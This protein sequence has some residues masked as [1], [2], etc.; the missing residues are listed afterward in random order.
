MIDNEQF[1]WDSE[2]F[3]DLNES[4]IEEL[5][6]LAEEM[7]NVS[8][9]YEEKIDSILRRINE[10]DAYEKMGLELR[11]SIEFMYSFEETEK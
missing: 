8:D 7:G 1:A 6:E 4:D 9:E 5:E 3:V 10:S 11:M 2:D